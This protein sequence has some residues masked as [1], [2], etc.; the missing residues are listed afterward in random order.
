M[1]STSP[2]QG[3][4]K[5]LR[6]IKARF[7][8]GFTLVLLA[9]VFSASA[10]TANLSGPEGQQAG[11][12][13]AS[14][15]S[16]FSSSESSSVDGEKQVRGAKLPPRVN[17]TQKSGDGADGEAPAV[18]FTN[19]AAI[20]IPTSGSGSPYPSAIA[21]SGFT[22]SL[23]AVTVTINGFSHAFPD[24]VGLA[25]VGPT[26]QA[27]L[28]Q[29]GAGDGTDAVNI[30]YTLSDLGGTDLPSTGTWANGTYMPTSYYSGDSFP[31]PGPGLVYAHPGPAGGN[32]ATLTGAF[33]GTNP[34]GTWN[35]YVVDFVGG[36]AGSIA[37]GWSIDITAP[38]GTCAAPPAN[39]VAW[40]P[41]EINTNDIIGDPVNNG[42]FQGSGAYTTGVVGNAFNFT[43]SNN[44]QVPTSATLNVGAAGGISVDAWIRP[45]TLTQQAVVEW[46]RAPGSGTIGAHFYQSVGTAGNLYVNL[47][48]TAGANHVFQTTTG[49]LAAGTNQHVAFTYDKVTGAVAIY[50]NGVAQTL[51]TANVGTGFTPGTGG[52]MY[53]GRRTTGVDFF[54]GVMDE[55]EIF[56]R[57]ITGA[58]VASIFTAG[59]IGKCH[60]SQIQFDLPAQ[61]VPENGGSAVTTIKRVGANDSTATVAYNVTPGTATGGGVDY[62]NASTSIVTFSPGE[63]TQT[64]SVPIIDDAIDEVDET[65]TA[66]ISLPTGAGVGIGAPSNQIITIVDN[67]AV[68][69][70][71]INS[72]SG[73]EGNPGPAGSATFTVTK[74]GATTLAS[75]VVVTPTS[76]TATGGATCAAGVDFINT[77]TTLNFPA[78]LTTDTQ[79]V[80]V[81]FCA[82]TALEADETFTMVLTPTGATA[83]AAGTGTIRDDDS[84]VQFTA[85]TFAVVEGTI[86]GPGLTPFNI[87]VSRAANAGAT[88]LPAA[89]VD[90]STIQVGGTANGENSC[91]I[92]G[93]DYVV[94][95][96]QT[97]SWAAGDV[98]N[99]TLV[100]NVCADS[101]NESNE[102]FNAQLSNALAT[103]IGAPA[104]SV[105]TITDD[106]AA[107]LF[108]LTGVPAAVTEGNSG[109]TP[110]V[111]TITRSGNGSQNSSTINWSIAGS[112]GNPASVTGDV[113]PASGSVT[114]PAGSGGT[115]TFTTN[116]VGDLLFEAN[117]TYT[118]T[119]AIGSNG[120]LSGA[121]SGQTTINNDD[122]APTVAIND[123]TQVELNSGSSAFIFTVTRTGDA[124]ANQTMVASTANGGGANVPAT[125]PSD[126]TQIIGDT[127]TFTQGQTSRQVA[128]I[129]NGDTIFEDNENFTVNLGT[130]NFGSATD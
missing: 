36:D 111:W 102:S 74:T 121:V 59:A 9:A 52:S 126:Y 51:S 88:G 76:G 11:S 107:P 78:S 29:D 23:T 48:D 83:G 98:A 64:V 85:G 25:L 116:V 96:G 30:T 127:V 81:N 77:A 3:L 92:A 41:G 19:P 70:I 65:F 73:I 55:V 87:T 100:V 125:F 86:A 68:P 95:S 104:S 54:V 31:G 129:V 53:I 39:M 46:E 27:F 72:A 14:L 80:T 13:T 44:V 99:K 15:F 109:T 128:V 106:D 110:Q 58:E 118:A 124:Q 56:S 38:A 33:G 40:Y 6:S 50:L 1:S 49:V 7:I 103:T 8:V 63:R 117:E 26:G 101:L 18:T 61:S 66:S 119:I 93:A 4:S 60:V 16:L 82:D 45:T 115:Q 12:F 105:N 47:Q 108:T 90:A 28:L 114:F 113:G 130:F 69:V 35:L 62:G 37:G 24:D 120:T 112:G 57:A 20:T 79:T 122:S 21:V 22:G 2:R 94:V 91:A 97:L 75:S 42:T 84:T 71:S 43:G 123:V 67:D 32:T 10:L 89:A 17:Q 5:T 34:N